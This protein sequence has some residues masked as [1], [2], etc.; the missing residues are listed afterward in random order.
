MYRD[1]YIWNC[2][3]CALDRIGRGDVLSRS[4][5]LVPGG[6]RHT[7]IT[8]DSEENGRSPADRASRSWQLQRGEARRRWLRRSRGISGPP[9]RRASPLCFSRTEARHIVRDDL[10]GVGQSHATLL[11]LLQPL[12]LIGFRGD[13]PPPRRSTSR[14]RE[15]DWP[16]C[17]LVRGKSCPPI[18]RGRSQG[19]IRR[20]SASDARASQEKSGG[21]VDDVARGVSTPGSRGGTVGAYRRQSPKRNGS[22]TF[23]QISPFFSGLCLPY[24]REQGATR[25]VG[26]S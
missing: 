15:G 10:S 3:C 6:T 2:A 19:V 22:D 23:S 17:G 24:L 5:D 21:L 18:L 26:S 12:Q 11:S 25:V 20:Y 16:P 1:T 4:R 13:A 9:S 14:E 8:R 7:R